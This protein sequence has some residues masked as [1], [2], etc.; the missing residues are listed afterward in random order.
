MI[1]LEKIMKRIGQRDIDMFF[2]QIRDLDEYISKLKSENPE[3]EAKD[4][5][6]KIYSEIYGASLLPQIE[7][8]GKYRNVSSKSDLFLFYTLKHIIKNPS[9][10]LKAYDELSRQEREEIFSSSNLFIYNENINN[11]IKILLKDL[12]SSLKK[13][14]KL[15]SGDLSYEQ[16]KKLQTYVL[17]MVEEVMQ[18]NKYEE[19]IK[20]GYILRLSSIIQFLDRV[21]DL[22]KTNKINN[23]RLQKM[24]L[25]DELGFEYSRSTKTDYKI[26]YVKDLKDKKSL[27]KLSIDDLAVLISFYYNRLEKI[28]ESIEKTLFILE[29]RG[30]LERFFEG[31]EIRSKLS[32][33]DLKINLAQF[34]FLSDISMKVIEKYRDNLIQDKS[35][36]DA[37]Y[38]DGKE[39]V[40]DQISMSDEQAY[41]NFFTKKD[42][43]SK[44]DAKKDLEMLMGYISN[45]NNVYFYK[46]CF[47]DVMMY[48]LLNKDKE[49]NWGYVEEKDK[50]FNNENSIK[51]NSRTILIKADIPGFNNPIT[52]HYKLKKLRTFIK[53]Y[54]GKKTI[55]VY[56]G[57]DDFEIESK[58]GKTYMSNLILM[59]IYS[60]RIKRIKKKAIASKEN[61][62]YNKYL[63]HLLWISSPKSIPEHLLKDGRNLKQRADLNTGEIEEICEE[64]G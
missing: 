17:K 28:I 2:M 10:I 16:R 52:L 22:E 47:M 62:P 54:N 63:K 4:L 59:P 39:G 14:E 19:F 13:N 29:K 64:K 7:Y 11:N 48:N 49:I 8:K 34:K 33:E 3:L 6:E 51:N 53:N 42:K 5:K 43:E 35:I 57:E 44:V 40:L 20:K 41:K 37:I 61:A 15:L 24:G 25:I 45:R 26:N 32:D 31:K 1:D 58:N 21:G 18:E 50:F 55:P 46:D 23:Y 56:Q 27:E 36:K 30:H 60:S 12:L 9:S 38:I